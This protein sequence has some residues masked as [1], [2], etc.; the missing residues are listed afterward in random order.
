MNPC[1]KRG[2][3]DWLGLSLVSWQAPSFSHWAYCLFFT[4]GR[5]IETPYLGRACCGV[6][7]LVLSYWAC[8]LLC[9]RIGLL[10]YELTFRGGLSFLE[11]WVMLVEQC[12]FKC[13]E[14][15]FELYLEFLVSRNLSKFT[16]NIFTYILFAGVVFALFVC[17]NRVWLCTIGWPCFLFLGKII[18]FHSP[19][20]S[21][22]FC[23]GDHSVR[24]WEGVGGFGL[25]IH[26]F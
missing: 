11:V 13:L 20:P 1:N 19:P 9:T 12:V 4:G 16:S 23:Y 8:L 24:S 7:A 17:A 14:L 22:L 26:D 2:C 10:L 18:I 3:W 5:W 25:R 21:I 15:L 6:D